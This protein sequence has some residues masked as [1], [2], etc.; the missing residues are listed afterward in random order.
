MESASVPAEHDQQEAE[1]E[2]QEAQ[3]QREDTEHCMPPAEVAAIS[4]HRPNAERRHAEGATGS[5]Q[6]IGEVEE[7]PHDEGDL[8]HDR[9]L[10][11]PNRIAKQHRQHVLDDLPAE[12]EEDRDRQDIDDDATKRVTIPA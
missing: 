7:H 9:R 12:G 4:P 11:E 3:Q 8:R 1:P 2:E 6:R 10:G 5:R